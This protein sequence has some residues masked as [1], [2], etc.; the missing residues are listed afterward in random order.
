MKSNILVL[1]LAGIHLERGLH[2]DIAFFVNSAVGSPLDVQV[3][4]DREPITPV[5][6]YEYIETLLKS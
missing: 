4:C 6:L 3:V 1:P 2:A 5:S